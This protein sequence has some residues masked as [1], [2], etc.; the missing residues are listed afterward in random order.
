M[1][2]AA[3]FRPVPRWLAIAC[4]VVALTACEP[5]AP[6]ATPDGA[7]RELIEI[8]RAYSGR[9]QD[10]KQA[11]DLLS[12]RAKSNLRARAERYGAASG[13]QI[14]PWAMLVPA[15]MVISFVP[16]AYSAQIVGKYALVDVIGVAPDQHAQVPCVLEDGAWHVDLVL[17]ELPPI[18][19]RP[20]VEP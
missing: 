20:G 19:T 8:M 13:R 15:R 18:E 7:V 1:G 6:N 5:A 2:D 16:Q 9:E 3:K 10:A 4:A 12:E 17:P 11:F 14:A